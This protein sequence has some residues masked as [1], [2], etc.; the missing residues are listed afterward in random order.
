MKP[1]LLFPKGK[2]LWLRGAAAFIA[3]AYPISQLYA[4]QP[5]ISYD[6]LFFWAV[7]A[8]IFWFTKHNDPSN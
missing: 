4:G 1:W 7:A 5:L 8:T 6:T 3:I 2:R